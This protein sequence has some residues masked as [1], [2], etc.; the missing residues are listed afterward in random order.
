MYYRWFLILVPALYDERPV[1]DFLVTSDG[2]DGYLADKGFSPI[3]WEKHWLELYGE[4]VAPTLQKSAR[5]AWPEARGSLSVGGR[6][7]SDH[8]RCDLAAQRLLLPGTSPR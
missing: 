5:R 1:G 8:R 4:L 2:Y 3:E 7:A 6:Q